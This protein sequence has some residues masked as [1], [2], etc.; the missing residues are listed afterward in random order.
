[1]KNNEG[2]FE[3]TIILML[4]A[5][6]I[7]FSLLNM[8]VTVDSGK[9]IVAR[10]E[11]VDDRVYFYNKKMDRLFDTYTDNMAEILA[12]AHEEI[13]F[14]KEQLIQVA[15]ITGEIFIEISK[16]LDSLIEKDESFIS[17][18]KG[19]DNAIS[20]LVQKDKTLDELVKDFK[21]LQLEETVVNQEKLVR[22]NFIVVDTKE[23]AQGSGTLI[24]LK[25]ELYILTCAHVVISEDIIM[26]AIDNKS[27]YYPIE[28][29]KLDKENDLALFKIWCEDI[30]PI[31]ISEE[32]PK[33]GDKIFLVGNPDGIEDMITDGIISKVAFY[34]SSVTVTVTTAKSYGGSSGGAM[35]YKGKIAGVLV[36]GLTLSEISGLLTPSPRL[37]YQSYSGVV[38]YEDVMG[39][40]EEY[41]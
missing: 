25:G 12:V 31:E 9:D 18:I 40:L 39:F 19:I 36:R 37:Y 3:F 27:M 41:R 15:G 26:T 1:M 8:K 17:I 22:A 13:L 29:V 2:L 21:D 32:A 11:N 5:A 30:E 33:A 6:S 24:R 35:L 10:I 14:N 34:W 28:L 16:T 20:N 7:C 38:P 4:V 23:G